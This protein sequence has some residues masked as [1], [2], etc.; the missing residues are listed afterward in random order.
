MKH[1]RSKQTSIIGKQHQETLN[2]K[3]QSNVFLNLNSRHKHLQKSR[4]SNQNL[5]GPIM[6][7]FKSDK[8]IHFF[9][10]Y[11]K[12]NDSYTSYQLLLRSWENFQ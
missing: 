3:N 10:K 4:E 9:L 1:R 12:V 5:I 11:F 2:M 6:D 7:Q 8:K